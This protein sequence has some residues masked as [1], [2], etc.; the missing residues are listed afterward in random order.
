[1]NPVKDKLNIDM[2]FSNPGDHVL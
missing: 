2:N 1:M